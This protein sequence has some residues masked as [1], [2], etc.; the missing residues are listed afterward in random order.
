MPLQLPFDYEVLA[1]HREGDIRVVLLKLSDPNQTEFVTYRVD[2]DG[3]CFWGHYL[4]TQTTAYIDFQTRT[5]NHE[6]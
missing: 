4:S 6:G 3:N 1:D 5:G 2:K